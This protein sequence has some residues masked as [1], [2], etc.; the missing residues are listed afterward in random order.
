MS[1]STPASTHPSAESAV[2]APPAGAPPRPPATRRLLPGLAITSFVLFATY[3]G[4]HL[5]AAAQPGARDRRGEQ[6]LEPR[7][8]HHGVVHLHALRP[9]DRRRVQRPHPLAARPPGTVDDH[10]RRRRRDLPRR[11]SGSLSSILWITVFWVVIQVSLNA[12]QGPLTA[13]VPDRFPRQRRGVASAMV[14][15]G[16][17][18]GGTVGVVVASS[19]RQPRPRLHGLRRGRARRHARCFVVLQPRLLAARTPRSRPWSWKEFLAGFWINPR[20]QPRLRVGLRRPVPVHPRL[21]RDRRLPAVHPHRLHRPAGRRGERDDRP[22]E[23]RR[24][25][26]D[27]RVHRHRAGGGAT[28]SAAARS[29]STPPPCSWS[30]ASRSRWSCR[31]SRACSS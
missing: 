26:H 14:G 7:D 9:A 20:K 8:R 2:E 4:P 11:A 23:P 1:A 22:P 16:T 24:H 13:I 30:S 27:A 12:L 6:G 25:G 28:S 17:M 15:I 21:L 31:T 3:C 5:A 29:S 19:S 10:R 18:V